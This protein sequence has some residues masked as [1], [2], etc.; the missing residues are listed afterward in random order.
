MFA[1]GVLLAAALLAVSASMVHQRYQPGEK[2]LMVY[3]GVGAG[4]T[5]TGAEGVEGG[6]TR[7]GSS[8]AQPRGSG[9]DAEGGGGGAAGGGGGK[10]LPPGSTAATGARRLQQQLGAGSR[11]RRQAPRQQPARHH[12]QRALRGR[13]GVAAS[14]GAG[15][16]LGV[17]MCM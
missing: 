15:M 3:A 11:R 14:P 7:S 13:A 10:P 2:V 8:A 5:A 17:R 1:A 6:Q 4:G 9:S 12:L 16:H